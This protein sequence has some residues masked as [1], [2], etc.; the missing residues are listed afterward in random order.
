MLRQTLVHLASGWER[1]R[2]Y[3]RAWDRRDNSVTLMWGT[4]PGTPKRTNAP[5]YDVLVF[6]PGVSRAIAHRALDSTIGESGGGATAD[7][8]DDIHGLRRFIDFRQSDAATR[9]F[10]ARN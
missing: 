9:E 10:Q 7:H 8:F 2:H 1:A 5:S 3:S 4:L 6:K